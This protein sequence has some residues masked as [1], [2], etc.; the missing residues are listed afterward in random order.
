MISRNKDNE[1]ENQQATA[2]RGRTKERVKMRE[3]KQRVQEG[4]VHKGARRGN[5][6]GAGGIEPTS[7]GEDKH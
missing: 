1:D 4:E 5:E 6:N 2:R 3:R 7:G